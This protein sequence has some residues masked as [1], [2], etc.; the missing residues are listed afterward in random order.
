MID[1]TKRIQQEIRNNEKFI[2]YN[3]Y[4]VIY[5]VCESYK[6]NNEIS[7]TFSHVKTRKERKKGTIFPSETDHSFSKM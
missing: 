5:I 1:F 7:H 4:K 3:N 6:F 2:K